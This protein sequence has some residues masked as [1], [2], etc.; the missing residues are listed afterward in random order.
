V[1]S[2]LPKGF[3]LGVTEDRRPAKN[4]DEVGKTLLEFFKQMGA[5]NGK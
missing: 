4:A 2:F 3:G 5:A 1:G